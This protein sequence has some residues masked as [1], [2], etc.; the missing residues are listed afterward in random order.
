MHDWH[1]FL[2]TYQLLADGIACEIDNQEETL[3]R[4]REQLGSR[5]EVPTEFHVACAKHAANCFVGKSAILLK[6]DPAIFDD[7]LT[8]FPDSPVDVS[9]I[10]HKRPLTRA[11]LWDLVERTF[12][13]GNMC[14]RP[15]RREQFLQTVQRL[16]ANLKREHAPPAN[17]DAPPVLPPDAVQAITQMFGI[18]N[19]AMKTI[20]N[21]IVGDMHNALQSADNPQEMVQRLLSGDMSALAR[22][23]EYEARMQASVDAG[24]V[25]LDELSAMRDSQAKGLA[26]LLGTNP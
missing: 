3:E 1:N 18:D 6:R 26:S 15:G 14:A 11:T 5:K 2:T 7:A 19:P 23:D 13:L 24:E 17:D 20:F 9:A 10:W 12:I 8:L 25:S 22:K 4:V 16:K 21:D